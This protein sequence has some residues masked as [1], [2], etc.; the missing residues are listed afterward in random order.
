MKGGQ[1]KEQALAIHSLQGHLT[2]DSTLRKRS[3]PYFQ[4]Q[5]TQEHWPPVSLLSP[6]RTLWTETRVAEVVRL[7]NSSEEFHD[8]LEY[9]K[10]KPPA[11]SGF[12]QQ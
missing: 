1:R 5:P 10:H 3:A 8:P 11:P 2:A 7:Y 4:T 6:L 12:A 9:P